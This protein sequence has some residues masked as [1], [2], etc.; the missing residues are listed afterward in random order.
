MSSRSGIQVA[1]GMQNHDTGPHAKR[2]LQSP[3]GRFAELRSSL[4]GLLPALLLLFP[5]TT[6]RSQEFDEAKS[7]VAVIVDTS[8]S[9]REPGMD[10]ERTS[11]L[12]TK[13]L[14]DLVPGE[15]A[16]VRLLDMVED[17]SLIPSKPTG[18]TRPCAEDP[19]RQCQVNAPATD[20]MADARSKRLGALVRPARGDE[21]FK[22]QL[23]SHLAQRINNS[24]FHLAFSAAAGIFEGRPPQ[25]S[26]L[27]KTVVWLSDGRSDDPAALTRIIG[28]LRGLRINIEAIVFGRGE[29]ALAEQA[30][31]QPLR[32][33]SPSELMKAFAGAFRRIVQAPYE[34]DHVISLNPSFEMKPHVDQAWIVVYGDDTLQD[35]ELRTPDGRRLI[36]DYAQ[37]RKP[38]AGAY[39][40]AYIEKPAAGDWNVQAQG[41]GPGAAY[42][43]VQRSALTPVLLEPSTT[44]AG[45]ETTLR[46]G[47]RAG[48]EGDIVTL[49]DLLDDMTVDVSHEG[50]TIRL[51]HDGK[52]RFSGSTRFDNPGQVPVQ[53]RARSSLVDRASQATVVVT[54]A[55][56]YA[57]PPIEIDLG[58]VELGQESCRDLRIDADQHSGAIEFILD[59]LKSLPAQHEL[60]VRAPAGPI[61]PDASAAIRAADQLQLCL[62]AGPRA[63]R[64]QARSEHW[65]DLRVAD[66]ELAQHRIPMRLSW[67]VNGLT[68]WQRWGWLILLI[69]LTLALAAVV[70]GYILPERF[71]GAMALVFV[72]DRE[73][74]D[75]QSPQPIKQWKG[76][77][78]G[79]YR[80]AQAFL[81]SNYRLSG[82]PKGA[83]ASLFA[84]KSGVRVSPGR[85]SSLFRETLD[86]EWESVQRQGRRGR[87]GDVYRCGESGPFFRI[88]SRRG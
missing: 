76:V 85:G 64:S 7:D 69:L 83:L 32:T 72:P 29:T 54:G 74:L 1:R 15:L 60:E 28:E 31:L 36:A 52:G 65:L 44:L 3:A 23:D 88:A 24:F 79:F 53:V 35:V 6:L 27:P 82:N 17:S 61:R 46:A 49:P 10:P 75:E 80:N 50:R 86:G 84:E 5:F 70:M 62:A 87:S 43:V 8:T 63:P 58:R 71:S 33:S 51:V 26:G 48:L 59:L 81:H 39:R 16:V 45:A 56:R 37:D 68:W 55:F 11:L 67:D 13:L 41:G 4:V 30:G 12:V 57:G 20:W 18:E 47:I 66:S 22:R 2:A 38:G 19:T 77:G 40:A 14:A 42:A 73:E 78:I 34:I 21:G 25:L 9:M